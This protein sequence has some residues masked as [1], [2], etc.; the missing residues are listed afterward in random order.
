M[1]TGCIV[2]ARNTSSRLPGKVT[3][4]LDYEKDTTVL[5]EVVSRLKKSKGIDAIIV[6]TTTNPED[7]SI[8]AIAK[9][10]GVS[11]FRGSENDVLERFYLA[12]KVNNLDT[13]IRITS[14]CPFIDYGVLDNLIGLYVKGGYDYASNCIR[15]T[16]PHGLDCEIFSFEALKRAYDSTAFV[17]DDKFY[18]EHVTTYLH[19]QPKLFKLGSLTDE[20]DNSGIRITVDTKQDYI[21]ACVLKS[22]LGDEYTYKD[23]VRIYKEK[24][25]LSEI[26]A[27]AMQKKRYESRED[28]IEAALKFLRLQEMNY[29]A[30]CLTE[31]GKNAKD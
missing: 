28:E 30:D 7:D 16:F 22:Y 14:D 21:L 3:K 5:E 24:P 12:A 15:R 2:Q 9:K 31:A 27:E 8:V 20:E 6:A 29:A 26:N 23:I 17:D 11:V 13:I 19:T 1:K 4:I 25:F 10:A 18:R